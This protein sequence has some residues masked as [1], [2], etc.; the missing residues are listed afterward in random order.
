MN[1]TRLQGHIFRINNCAKYLSSLKFGALFSLAQLL[2]SE[3]YPA[4]SDIRF[5]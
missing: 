4:I 5:R 3:L 2:K 1:I